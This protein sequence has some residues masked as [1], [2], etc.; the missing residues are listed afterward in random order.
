VKEPVDH[1][2]R[3]QLPWRS[4]ATAITECGYDASKVKALS[5]D[6]FFRRE[7]DFGKQ[8]SAM[9]TC[10]TCRDTALRWSRWQDDP[11]LGMQRE[12]EWERGGSYYSRGHDDRGCL[13][14]D[15]LNVIALLIET[16]RD[17]FDAMLAEI[18]QRREWNEKK[19]AMQNKPKEASKSGSL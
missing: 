9:L 4:A 7:K 17:E 13:L 1:I 10:M 14:R 8:R 15:E 18:I 5:R 2:V 16:H 12:I 6:E 11:R 3:P 19:V